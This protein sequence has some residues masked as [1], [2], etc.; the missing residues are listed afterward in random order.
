MNH[1]SSNKNL[2]LEGIEEE[3]DNEKYE[4]TNRKSNA[5]ILMGMGKM[6]SEKLN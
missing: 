4:Y 5:N 6:S 3:I 2:K 1:N